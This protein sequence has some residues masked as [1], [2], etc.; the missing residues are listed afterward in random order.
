MAFALALL[1]PQTT[2]LQLRYNPS[3]LSC[4]EVIS[5]EGTHPPHG[6][7]QVFKQQHFVTLILH[8]KINRWAV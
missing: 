8:K 3:A 7:M 4:S 1:P 6:E 2:A 5:A